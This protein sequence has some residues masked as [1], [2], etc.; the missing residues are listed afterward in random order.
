MAAPKRKAKKATRKGVRAPRPSESNGAAPAGDGF[1]RRP[2]D[3]A[4]LDKAIWDLLG[5]GADDYAPDD[6]RGLR[7][8]LRLNALYPGKYV[9]YRDHRDANVRLVYC[10][11]VAVARSWAALHK[12]IDA[13][14]PE[15]QDVM[16]TRVEGPQ[17]NLSWM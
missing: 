6:W 13:L 11:V 7:E 12:L 17:E 14:P 4:K 9:A 3:E 15:Q 5:R 10:E 2:E 1:R 8:H 16:V